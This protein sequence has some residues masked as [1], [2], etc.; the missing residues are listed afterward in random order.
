M[1]VFV[2]LPFASF[3]I[4]VCLPTVQAVVTVKSALTLPFASLDTFWPLAIGVLSRR[5]V[6]ADEPEKLLALTC[7]T[8]PVEPAGIEPYK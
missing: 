4:K 6:I 1:P 8:V 5:K 3:T 2:A 7:R